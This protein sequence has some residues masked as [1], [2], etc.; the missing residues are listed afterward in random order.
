MKK[1][2]EKQGSILSSKSQ[3]N[4]NEK[5]KKYFE[6]SKGSLIDKINSFTRYVPRQNIAKLIAQYELIKETK[7]CWEI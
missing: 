3:Y 7:V 2:K 4:L 1:N 5:R 6:N